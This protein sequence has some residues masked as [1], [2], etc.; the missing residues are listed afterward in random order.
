MTNEIIAFAIAL[1]PLS[2]IAIYHL[3]FLSEE[4]RCRDQMHDL[5]RA[6]NRSGAKFGKDGSIRRMDF[7]Q[8]KAWLRKVLTQNYGFEASIVERVLSTLRE[9]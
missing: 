7:K 3:F 8:T 9:K 6:L 2:I 1:G 4:D 5:L